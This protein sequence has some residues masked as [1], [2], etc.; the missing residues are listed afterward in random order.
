MTKTEELKVLRSVLN[1]I[2]NLLSEDEKDRWIE[3]IMEPAFSQMSS[4]LL[5]GDITEERLQKFKNTLHLIDSL[6]AGM[7]GHGLDA[8]NILDHTRVFTLLYSMHDILRDMSE[9]EVEPDESD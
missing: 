1:N 9:E 4:I 8:D 2:R 3:T 6:I 5:T 7:D